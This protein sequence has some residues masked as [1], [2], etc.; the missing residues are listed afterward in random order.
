MQT[1]T[2]I[3][4]HICHLARGITTKTFLKLKDIIIDIRSE[5]AKKVTRRVRVMARSVLT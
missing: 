1:L 3:L 4:E 5:K 2:K